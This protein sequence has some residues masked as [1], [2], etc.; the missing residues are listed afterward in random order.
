M[1]NM[2]Q[3]RIVEQ[4]DALH[5]CSNQHKMWK[6]LSNANR[7]AKMLYSDHS[8]RLGVVQTEIR[9]PLVDLIVST[10]R[11]GYIVMHSN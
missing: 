10:S 7:C 3:R 8:Y 11:Y 9:M 2:S 4:T 1:D 5:C 6:Q